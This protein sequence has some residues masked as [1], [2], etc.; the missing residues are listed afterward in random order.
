MDGKDVMNS[1]RYLPPPKELDA[2]EKG[3]LIIKSF[4]GWD[5]KIT[6]CIKQ[7]DFAT[8][9]P[10][11]KNPTGKCFNKNQSVLFSSKSGYEI[12]GISKTM[13]SFIWEGKIKV[14]GRGK[15]GL[16]FDP[17]FCPDT[18]MGI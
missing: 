14:T 8:F 5:K 9:S 10:L 6:T 13:E 4:S 12:F 2:D 16:I 7:I 3:H 18:R 17:R 1:T 11:M 15:C